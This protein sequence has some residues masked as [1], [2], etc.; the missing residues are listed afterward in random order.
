MQP[1]TQRASTWGA[2]EHGLIFFFF[3]LSQKMTWQKCGDKKQIINWV[4]FY[5]V[6]TVDKHISLKKKT[7]WSW[8]RIK[9]GH[10]VLL[11]WLCLLNGTLFPPSHFQL[12]AKQWLLTSWCWAQTAFSIIIG[13]TEV[14]YF[15]SFIKVQ[16]QSA[17]ISNSYIGIVAISQLIKN[18]L[19]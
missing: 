16:F 13:L 10:R 17:I 19:F 4:R 15:T 14:I 18:G 5:F 8:I 2:G 6:I 7:S 12:K 1:C 9:E 11:Y 3:L